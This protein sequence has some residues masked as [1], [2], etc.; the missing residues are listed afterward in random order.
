MIREQNTFKKNKEAKGHGAS[1]DIGEGNH[2]QAM[3][4]KNSI[5]RTPIYLDYA[6]FRCKYCGKKRPNKG[7]KIVHG[8]RRC[9][10]CA[11]S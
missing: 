5:D 7:S 6:T 8:F 11:K 4:D 10:G 1:F 9:Q 3:K 2:I